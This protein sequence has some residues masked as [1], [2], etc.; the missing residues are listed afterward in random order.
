LRIRTGAVWTS[1]VVTPSGLAQAFVVEVVRDVI[2][3]RW[4]DFLAYS[5]AKLSL[6]ALSG[7]G[8][9]SARDGVWIATAIPATSRAAETTDLVLI[10][11]TPRARK[12]TACPTTGQ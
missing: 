11:S 10:V 8:F 7:A 2:S 6:N 4:P 5:K 9:G 12:R 1:T 3:I